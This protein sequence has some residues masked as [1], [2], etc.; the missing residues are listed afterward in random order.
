MRD[1][2]VYCGGSPTG[3]D[4][5]RPRSGGGPD[6]WENR[7]PACSDCDGSKANAPLLVYLV[8]VAH[9]STRLMRRTYK[10]PAIRRA[11]IRRS[12]MT[13]AAQGGPQKKSKPKKERQPYVSP[14]LVYAC[15]TPEYWSMWSVRG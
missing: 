8:S 9:A 13:L 11:A 14:P 1:P 6:G 3:L 4:H 10:L 15:N 12:A 7:A 5:I 2:C